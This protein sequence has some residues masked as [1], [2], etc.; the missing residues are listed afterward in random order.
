MNST[1]KHILTIWATLEINFIFGI[2]K[3]ISFKQNKEIFDAGEN[4]TRARTGN[5]ELIAVNWPY[6]DFLKLVLSSK[7]VTLFSKLKS[8]LTLDNGTNI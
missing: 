5:Y 4:L 2:P 3:K 7:T 8:N 1:G 6:Y